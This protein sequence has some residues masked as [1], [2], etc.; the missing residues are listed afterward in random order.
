M[1]RQ[2][3]TVEFRNPRNGATI[4]IPVEAEDEP[5]AVRRARA[6]YRKE[7]RIGIDPTYTWTISPRPA[8]PKTQGQIR[9][10]EFEPRPEQYEAD[11]Q[12]LAD[13]INNG[14]LP[15]RI[16][17]G[18]ILDPPILRYGPADLLLRLRTYDGIFFVESLSTTG[19]GDKW[20]GDRL[21]KYLEKLTREHQ[22]TEAGI[23]ERQK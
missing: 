3:F 14:T 18:L 4:P 7:H 13:G 15:D 11:F 23:A 6:I 8:Q 22:R 17:I 19:S 5:I 9:I 2:L 21:M 12:K 10:L 20:T 16:A 1:K